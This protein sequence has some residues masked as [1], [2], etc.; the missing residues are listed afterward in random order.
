MGQLDEGEEMGVNG[1]AEI[2]H[3]D[4]DRRLTEVVNAQLDMSEKIGRL[5]GEIGAMHT[6]VRELRITHRQHQDSV[7]DLVDE[8]VRQH[9][10]EHEAATWRWI[11]KNATKVMV[12][13]L[14]ALVG[15]E[16]VM[17]IVKG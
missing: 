8:L 14:I 13:V 10:T 11:K 3:E 9:D 4:L 15:A 7:P 16:L 6:I 17:R 1:R 2:T 5:A 12:G